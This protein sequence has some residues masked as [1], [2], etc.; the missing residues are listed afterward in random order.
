MKL[1][2]FDEK[3]RSR[4][5]YSIYFFYL[6]LKLPFIGDAFIHTKNLQYSKQVFSCKHYMGLFFSKANYVLLE[7][8]KVMFLGS[9]AKVIE[10]NNRFSSDTHLIFRV[11]KIKLGE[12]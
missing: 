6:N 2:K 5:Y 4:N 11:S 1:I 10:I 9:V 8:M 3:L 7:E 12:M